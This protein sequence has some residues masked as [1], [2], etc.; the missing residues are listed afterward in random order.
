MCR[1][2]DGWE[3]AVHVAAYCP[4]EVSTVELVRTMELMSV[5]TSFTVLT[6]PRQLVFR[7]LL[8]SYFRN[9]QMLIS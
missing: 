6:L 7:K 1:C 9:E 2:G 5:L 8:D 3:T 4:E